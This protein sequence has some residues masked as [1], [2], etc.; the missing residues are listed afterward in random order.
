M[1]VFFLT[2]SRGEQSG[3]GPITTVLTTVTVAAVQVIHILVDHISE[4]VSN[5]RAV[6]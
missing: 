4:M 2:D 6:G 5:C 1:I 3:S